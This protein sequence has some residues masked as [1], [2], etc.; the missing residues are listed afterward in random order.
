[1]T[2]KQGLKIFTLLMTFF[3]VG[4]TLCSCS[5]ATG[6]NE[7]Q[8]QSSIFEVVETTYNYEIVYN[9]ATKVMYAV[10]DGVHN[11]GT[12]TLLVNPDGTPMIY[13]GE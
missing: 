12:F 5:S 10:S 3:I 11:H 13:K 1:M 9:K 6:N 8:N 7:T 2:N 4:I